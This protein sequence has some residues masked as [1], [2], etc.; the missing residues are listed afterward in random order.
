MLTRK[1]VSVEKERKKENVRM[2]ACAL[3]AGL[4]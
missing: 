4:K 3:H 2:C 1:I